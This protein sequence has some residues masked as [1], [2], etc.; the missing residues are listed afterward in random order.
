[1][2]RTIVDEQIKYTIIINGASAKKELHTLDAETRQL[3][4]TN[5]ELRLEKARLAAAGNKESAAYKAITK[6]ITANNLALK[7]NEARM[8]ELRAERGVTGLTMAQL[9]SESK[10]LR[11]ALR[12]MAPGSADFKRYQNELNQVNNRLRELRMGANQTKFSLAKL[13]DEFNRYQALGFS[14]VAAVTGVVISFQKLIDFQ[15]KLS[16]AQAD[17]AKTTNLSAEAVEELT[18]SLGLFKTRTARIELL[19]LAE[20]AGRLGKESKEDILE[21]VQVADQIKVALGDDLQGDVNENIRIIGKLTEQYQVGSDIGASFGEGMTMIGSA[22]NEVASSGAAQAGYLVDYTSR[23]VGISRQANISAQDQIGFAA[24]L[25]EAGQRVE[26]S[27]TATS[28]AIIGMFKDT[29]TYAGIAGM[30]VT[31]FRKLLE[32][33]ANEAFLRFLQGLNGNNA[34]LEELSRKFDGLG[35]DGS[36]AISVLATLASQT[37]KIREKQT[38][39]NDSRSVQMR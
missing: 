27:A 11:L 5:K 16:D 6:E 12:H 18:A 33:D 14:V 2:A 23:L 26:T 13:G 21:F 32:T 7:T 39:A 34:G 19:Q 29:D 22:I 38:L 30:A 31:D 8:K 24:V 25:D 9:E 3:N 36:R 4:A 15:G 28:Q 17:V 10:K 1:M 37:E 20:E 35:I